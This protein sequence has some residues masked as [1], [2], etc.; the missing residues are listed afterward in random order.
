[1]SARQATKIDSTGALVF[2]AAKDFKAQNFGETPFNALD[3][4]A[5]GDGSTDDTT[6][7]QAAI[8]SA[9][10]VNRALYLP[11]GTYK[12]SD[13]LIVPG[14]G[15]RLLGAGGLQTQIWQSAAAKNGL[16]LTSNADFVTLESIY[17]TGVGK[18]IGGTGTPTGYGL[19]SPASAAN[20]DEIIV[21]DCQFEGFAIGVNLQD[22]A[23]FLFER[24]EC[25]H[26]W[27]GGMIVGGH[28]N[29]CAYLDSAWV[30]NGNP[31]TRGGYG[32]QITG[33]SGHVLIGGEFGGPLQTSNQLVFGGTSLIVIGGNWEVYGGDA[34]SHTAATYLALINVGIGDFSGG[35][36]LGYSLVQTL[37]SRVTVENCLLGRGVA[38]G[39]QVK[40]VYA[41][42]TTLEVR[43]ASVLVESYNGSGV[44]SGIWQSSALVNL[45]ECAASGA[46]A[47]SMK[48]NVRRRMDS[49]S[50][51]VGTLE[52]WD[53]AMRKADGTYEFVPLTPLRTANTWALAQT[54]TLVA[55]F[56][57]AI[58]AVDAVGKIQTAGDLKLGA[59]HY[60]EFAGRSCLKSTADG[61]LSCRNNADS[62]DSD[63]SAKNGTFSGP[64]KLPSYT[65]SGVPS[66]STSGAGAQIYVSN[67]TG[68]A[69]TAFSDGTNWR[70]VT[71]RAIIS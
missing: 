52:T 69:V 67:E 49:D 39:A 48:G 40:Q 54:F 9:H 29:G 6:A 7:L 1:M 36:A 43:G 42:S 44:L 20:I 53:A 51:G 25:N 22:V 18:L 19:I 33:G 15:F 37:G 17:I 34:I 62:A 65:V 50:S 56:S 21:R 38:S 31:T 2:P 61:S 70:R 23:N 55:T 57:G 68:G 47:A 45:T 8:T 46:S 28:S 10:A 14:G 35:S 30:Q 59:T 11:A 27:T 60:L 12:I 64:V 41:I 24:S 3:Y 26:N 66:A 71:D 32:L 4:G 58:I 16:T 63:I 13:V 5:T